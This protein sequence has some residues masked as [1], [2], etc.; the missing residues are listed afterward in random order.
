MPTAWALLPFVALAALLAAIVLAFDGTSLYPIFLLIGYPLLCWSAVAAARATNDLL[1]PLTVLLVLAAIRLL[2]PAALYNTD[3]ARSALSTFR[4]MGLE[5]DDWR[6]G[7]V[8][9]VATLIALTLGWL[10]GIGRLPPVRVIAP[11]ASRNSYVTLAGIAIGAISLGVFVSLNADLASVVATGAFRG[12]SIQEGT[13]SLFLLSFAMIAGA[14]LITESRAGKSGVALALLPALGVAALYFVLG[15]RARTITPVA[16][17][18]LIVWYLH[19]ATRRRISGRWWGLGAVAVVVGGWLLYAG[20]MYRAGKLTLASAFS[21]SDFIGY[22]REALVIDIGQLHGVAGAAKIG[23][24]AVGPWYVISPFLWP[25]NRLFPVPA[26]EVDRLDGIVK[27]RA[28]GR[29]WAFHTAFPGDMYIAFGAAGVLLGGI[30][31]GLVLARCYRQFYLGRFSSAVYAL[32]LVYA[33]RVFF[34]G[35]GKWTELL[36][37]VTMAL[38]MI[39]ASKLVPG[40]RGDRG[41]PRPDRAD[42]ARAS[43]P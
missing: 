40:G 43:L 41:K 10:L 11:P 7:H 2:L 12:I 8:L 15:G 34:E 14:A 37:V 16:A 23:A 24:G 38:V 26:G 35:I 5:P 6:A 21:G 17:A 18:L 19:G 25:L 29:S 20:A 4:L 36:V 27:F 31:V 30:L 13:G 32:V 1:N 9:V 39:A 28:A 3:S 22:I 33:V 42:R